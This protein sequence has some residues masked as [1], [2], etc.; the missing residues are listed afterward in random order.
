MM[1]FE[2]K[3]PLS[4]LPLQVWRDEKD[5]LEILLYEMPNVTP[6]SWTQLGHRDSGR[7][8]QILISNT[9]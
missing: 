4:S 6:R 3:H 8:H 1:G 2:D 7:E 9:R 5:D